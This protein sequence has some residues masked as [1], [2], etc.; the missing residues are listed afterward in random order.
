MIIKYAILSVIF[1]I[2]ISFFGFNLRDIIESP[3]TQNNLNY[4]WSGVVYVW[5]NFLKTPVVYIWEKIIKGILWQAFIH[6]LERI[7]AGAPTELQEAG[8]RLMETG[9]RG[10]VPLGQR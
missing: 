3:T 7:D 4:A 5:D 10:Y 9:E 1:I 6:N 8:Q 2:I